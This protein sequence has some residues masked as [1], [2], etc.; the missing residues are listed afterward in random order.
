MQVGQTHSYCRL[1]FDLSISGLQVSSGNTNFLL[2]LLSTSVQFRIFVSDSS[3]AQPRS[4]VSKPSDSSK[5]PVTQQTV[6]LENFSQRSI[7]DDLQLPP[8]L[9]PVVSPVV[10]RLTEVPVIPDRMISSSK[11]KKKSSGSVL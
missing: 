1:S 8:S 5:A 6:S 11:Q 2:L 7:P 3:P 9:T 10:Q 4:R